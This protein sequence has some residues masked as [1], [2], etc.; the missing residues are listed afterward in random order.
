M[1]MA[2]LP[3]SLPVHYEIYFLKFTQITKLFVAN[4]IVF[5]DKNVLPF[6]F[7]SNKVKSNAQ[8]SLKQFR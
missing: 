5:G 1:A 7:Q 6:S 8:I 4:N 3:P 2:T